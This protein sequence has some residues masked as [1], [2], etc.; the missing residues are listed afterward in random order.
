MHMENL[1][2]IVDS[3][4]T[5]ADWALT[6][7]HACSRRQSVGINPF[8]LDDDA[9]R[10]VVLTAFPEAHER[11][12][13]TAVRFY[14]AGCRDAQTARMNT[15]LEGCFPGA[16][17]MVASD[18]LAAA[19]AVCGRRP[20]IACILGTG[21]NS[22]RYDG[23]NITDNV[24]PLGYILGDE[25]SGA[26]LG[27]RLLGDVF[28]RRLSPELCK[29]FH[30]EHPLS[31]NDVIERVYRGTSPNR[32][33]AQF[34][35]FLKKHE[36]EP[37]IDALL[38]EEFTRFFVR[39]VGAYGRTLPVGFVGSVAYF[40]SRQLTACAGSLGYS[41]SDIIRAPFERLENL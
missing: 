27:R 30:E 26:V 3:G 11:E 14:G 13:V 25:G 17:V 36:D 29:R 18:L 5:K 39:N 34:T 20:G 8:M 38:N 31:V 32:F 9:V 6:D 37:E 28:K 40:F 22:C 10:Q 16:S 21:A 12:A 24:P 2:L 15:L 23:E 33:L 7:G 1:T 41:I 4:S 35:T 19:K